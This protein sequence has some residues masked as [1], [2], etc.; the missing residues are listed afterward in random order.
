[1]T[2]IGSRTVP[3]A[4]IA[5]AT[6]LTMTAAA[7]LGMSRAHAQEDETFEQGVLRKFMSG[8]GLKSSGDDSGI[9]YRERAPLVVPPSRDLPPPDTTAVATKDP[10]WP[11]DPDVKQRKDARRKQVG[12]RDLSTRLYQ[13][14]LPSTPAELEKG[15]IAS[16]KQVAASTTLDPTA[17]VKPSKLGYKGGFFDSLWSKVGPAHDEVAAFTAE[18]PRTRLVEPP[19][20]YQTPAPNQPYGTVAKTQGNEAANT[21]L[22]D[23][24]TDYTGH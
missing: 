11:V 5:L 10:A 20:G 19:A 22:K 13:E 7:G 8:I 17:P 2:M 12:Q 23:R 9:Q 1:M 16:D 18:P 24:G 3:L 4:R 21:F 14:S 15:R 6:A